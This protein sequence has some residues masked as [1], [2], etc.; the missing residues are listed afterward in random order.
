MVATDPM[1]MA[2][3]SDTRSRS[4][5]KPINAAVLL[6]N[7]INVSGDYTAS[8]NK[9]STT[10]RV[11]VG[12]MVY[13]PSHSPQ[14]FGWFS[15]AFTRKPFQRFWMRVLVDYWKPLKQFLR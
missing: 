15:P 7:D 5:S 9:I 10:H 2:M 8:G 14:P 11:S 1:L 13:A 6:M 4:P 3:E 12:S